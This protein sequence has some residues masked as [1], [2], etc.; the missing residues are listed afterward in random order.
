MKTMENWRNSVEILMKTTEKIDEHYGKQTMK[1]MEQTMK[2]MEQSMI[3]ME[4]SMN[5]TEK[6][7]STMEQNNEN[8]GTIEK[9]H[10]QTARGS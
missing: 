4:Q 7:M 9:N 1:T 3:T 5:T 6:T 10:R 2:T 8:Y